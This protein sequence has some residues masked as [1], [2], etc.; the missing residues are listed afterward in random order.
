VDAIP[1]RHLRDLVKNCIS[2]H[3]DQDA[4]RVLKVAEQSERQI[5][6]R[7]S[8]VGMS[9]VGAEEEYDEEDEEADEDE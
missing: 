5:L 8:R 1:P 9:H 6:E 3:V 4:L 7:L 2:R